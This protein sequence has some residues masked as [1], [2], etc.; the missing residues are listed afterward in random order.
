LAV[1]R[2]PLPVSYAFGSVIAGRPI[3]VD[4]TDAAHLM[5]WHLGAS[6]DHPH[7][8]E[9]HG[10]DYNNYGCLFP[11]HVGCSPVMP[12]VNMPLG[13]AATRPKTRLL[14][15]PALRFAFAQL[16]KVAAASTTIPVT[17]AAMQEYAKISYSG[18]CNPPYGFPYS[19]RHLKA[20]LAP[21]RKGE[22]LRV[23]AVKCA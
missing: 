1:L 9:S 5:G 12:E 4:F 16:M 23:R 2:F 13:S 20:T 10:E 6:K 22:I 17:N 8:T 7:P 11:V 18:H 14:R 21:W 19:R 15:P 3:Y